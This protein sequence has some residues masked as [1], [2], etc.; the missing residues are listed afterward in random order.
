[1]T[2]TERRKIGSLMAS[3]APRLICSL[4]KALVRSHSLRPS[5]PLSLSL[6]FFLSLPPCRPHTLVCY[7]LIAA[8]I[9]SE[10]DINA[11]Q[12]GCRP[13]VPSGSPAMVVENEKNELIGGRGGGVVV[14]VVVWWWWCGSAFISSLIVRIAKKIK[15]EIP[16]KRQFYLVNVFK[17]EKNMNKNLY[18]NSITL[19]IIRF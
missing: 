11:I 1:M 17:K 14:M 16:S 5:Q 10:F 12:P 19:S 15:H 7:P 2:R 18:F 6:V 4:I 13:K 3:A 9:F 8:I